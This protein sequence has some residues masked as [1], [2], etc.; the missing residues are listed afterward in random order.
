MPKILVVDDEEKIRDILV[1]FME[2]AGFEVMQAPGGREAIET[3]R[4]DN[5]SIDLMVVDMKMPKV[6]GAD[7]LREKSRLGKSFPAILLTG[8]VDAEKYLMG[9]KDVGL[10]GEDICYKPVDLFVLLEMIKK[11]LGIAP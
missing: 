5:N 8:S 3:L 11:R 1:K 6:T 2:K 7:V 9:L 4:Q 10:T